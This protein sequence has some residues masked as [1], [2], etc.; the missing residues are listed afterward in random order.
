MEAK[1]EPEAV[2]MHEARWAMQISGVLH[3]GL[4]LVPDELLLSYSALAMGPT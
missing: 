4:W 3:P 2:R 1:E